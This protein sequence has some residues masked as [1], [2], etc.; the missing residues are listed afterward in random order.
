VGSLYQYFPNKE[1]LV[2]A[3]IDRHAQDIISVTSQAIALARDRP[4]KEGLRAVVRAGL[5]AH[6]IA[7]ALHKI[8][9]EQVPRVGR[10]AE[11][12]DTSRSLSDL[13][14]HLFRAHV[15]ELAPGRDPSIAALLIEVSLEAMTHKMVLERPELLNDG[16][17]ELQMYELCASYLLRDASPSRG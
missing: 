1:A 14:H 3:L 13:L 8:L 12:M 16:V 15:D 11:A 4:L 9:V 10:I 5:D 6:R 7:P 2:A 17:V